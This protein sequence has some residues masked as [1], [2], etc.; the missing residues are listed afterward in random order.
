MTAGMVYF[1]R[2]P[3]LAVYPYNTLLEPHRKATGCTKQE[4]RI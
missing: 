1:A 2:Y 4:G 3:T